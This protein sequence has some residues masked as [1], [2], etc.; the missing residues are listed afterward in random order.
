MTGK[1]MHALQRLSS[2]RING[3]LGLVFDGATALAAWQAYSGQD[4]S[5]TC[6]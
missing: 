3:R 5:S 1:P 2:S 4:S 6:P